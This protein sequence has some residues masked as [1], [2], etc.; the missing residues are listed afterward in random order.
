MNRVRARALWT[1]ARREYFSR[2]KSRSF[3]VS[4]ISLPA[5]MI[6]ASL[7]IGL[8]TASMTRRGPAPPVR[9]TV[10][11]A[12][13]RL[14]GMLR[15]L[16]NQ[17]APGFYAIE[18]GPPPSSEVQAQMTQ[19]IRESRVEA[20]LWVDLVDIE[21]GRATYQAGDQRAANSHW[22]VA[23]ALAQ[24]FARL[25]LEEHHGI[26]P[27][28][29]AR[30]VA[31]IELQPEMVA[32]APSRASSPLGAGTVA[33]LM[34]LVLFISLVTY[35]AMVMRGVL[36]EKSTRIPEV[37]L[38]VATSDELMAGK[39]IGIGAVGLT[40]IG[41]WIGFV[42]ATI[43]IG[44]SSG[45]FARQLGASVNMSAGLIATLVVFYILGYLLYSAMFAALGAAF[46][47]IDE[48]QQWTLPLLLPLLISSWIVVP[49]AQSPN[50]TFAF[51]VSMIPPM[52]PVMMTTRIATGALPLW[53]IVLSVL[54]LVATI[55]VTI[56]ICAR[57]YRVGILMYGKPPRPTE[58]LRW[59]RYS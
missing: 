22:L 54:L 7:A 11:S 45:A 20:V 33:L 55:A 6:I 31:P 38:C 40:Q 52:A 24:A 43:K 57:I 9:I 10:V 56:T 37:L 2:V 34:M 15:D 27:E 39:I 4:T 16:L 28:E 8:S 12:D 30:I 3:L 32:L 13:A 41:I 18:A 21:K 47:S 5:I 14:P 48:A 42:A 51:V 19:A 29:A 17:S 46:V 49:V 1:I 35:G 53:Q 50:S 59:L 44:A 36:E 25:R 23:A 58:I 26:A